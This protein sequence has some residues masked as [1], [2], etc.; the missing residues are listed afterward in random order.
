[1]SKKTAV[2]FPSWSNPWT[3]SASDNELS[4]LKSE[5]PELDIVY[6]SFCRPNLSYR[7]GSF[8]N[9]GLQF[10]SSFEVITESIRNLKSQGVTVMLSVG[11]GSYWSATTDYNVQDC[12][13]LCNDLGC[14]GIDI[15]WEG[16]VD[17][18][19]ELTDAIRKTKQFI[20]SRKLS[21]AAFSTGAYGKRPGSPYMGVNI[22]ALTKVGSM[23]DWINIMAYDAGNWEMY[24]PIS[25]FNCF[26]IYYEG[27]LHLGIQVGKQGWGDHLV[28]ENEVAIICD[29]ISKEVI[30]SG[31]FVWSYKKEG[32]PSCQR[33]LEISRGIFGDYT[34]DLS[35]PGAPAISCPVCNTCYIKK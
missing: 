20:G 5:M 35:S 16:T 3:S 25:A 27:P 21:F 10:S 11:G 15:D 32:T 2:Y 26:R 23:L 31:I 13:S 33:V 19:Y 28:S 7:K 9:T 34:P 6:L 14:D 22:D 1:M 29:R 12:I 18:D 24:N 4:N 30:E 8:D 17:R